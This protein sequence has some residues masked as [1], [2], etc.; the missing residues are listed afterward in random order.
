MIMINQYEPFGGFVSR[1]DRTDLYTGWV[2]A[3]ITHLGHKESAFCLILKVFGERLEPLCTALW[4]IDIDAVVGD[5]IP[6]HPC[7]KIALRHF[8]LFLTGSHATTP[9]DAL[10]DIDN[11]GPLVLAASLLPYPGGLMA[12]THPRRVYHQGGSSTRY[13]LFQKNPA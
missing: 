13:N 4:G 8:I 6:F 2:L 3:M 9:S 1:A 7:S 12:T 11:I 5:D 10:V